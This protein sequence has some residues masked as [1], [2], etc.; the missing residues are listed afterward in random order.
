MKLTSPERLKTFVITQDDVEAAR[1]GRPIDPRKIPQRELSR[2][3]GASHSLIYQLTSGRNRTCTPETAE[4]IAEV[5]GVDVTVL[6][7][8]VEPTAMRQ[9]GTGQASRRQAVPA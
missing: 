2:R 3:I 1:K 6:F 8:P 5:L 4:R 7:D 9:N